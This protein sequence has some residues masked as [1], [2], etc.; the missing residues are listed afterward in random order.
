MAS[1]CQDSA[2][3]GLEAQVNALESYR[4]VLE[5]QANAWINEALDFEATSPITDPADMLLDCVDNLTTATLGCEVTDV[6][7]VNDFIQ[8][9]KNK[10]R[11]EI[12]KK[13]NDLLWDTAQVAETNLAVLER[14]LCASL[15]DVIAFF[16]RYSLNRLL[17]AINRNQTCIT[18]S[19]EAAKY[20][21]DIDAQNARIDAVLDDLPVDSSGNFDLG[22]LTEDL[23][24]ALAENMEIFQTQSNAMNTAATENLQKQ[25]ANIGDI[26]PA[27]RF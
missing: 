15:A 2:I 18:S 24:P 9:C 4:D 27:N 8:D 12:N 1:A 13:V 21:A 22:K 11:A 17:D 25:L 14:F 20:A 26:N 23:S 3:R 10:L 19:A 5:V 16:E 6:P 7:S